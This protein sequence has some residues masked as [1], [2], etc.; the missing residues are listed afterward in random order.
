LKVPAVAEP[1]GK[2]KRALWA[3]PAQPTTRVER[4]AGF[5]IFF[6][7]NALKSHESKKLM[8]GNERKVSFIS[9]H[10]LAFP[11]EDFALRL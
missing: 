1:F 7:R 9:F 4:K 8:K 11:Y 3:L 6:V 10:K 5:F 2:E